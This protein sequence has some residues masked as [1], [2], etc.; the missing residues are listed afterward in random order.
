M[1]R[2]KGVNYKILSDLLNERILML[3][4]GM[5]T[6]VQRYRLTEDDFRGKRFADAKKVKY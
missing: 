2:S 1:L 3:D 4:G 5:G 6:M